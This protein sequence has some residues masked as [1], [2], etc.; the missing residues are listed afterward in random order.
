[1][2]N[3]KFQELV[4]DAYKKAKEGGNL[5][6]ILYSA[7]STHGFSEITDIEGYVKA[8]AT[9]MLYLKSKVTGESTDIY[10]YDLV[11]YKVRN[12]EKTIY[13]RLRNREILL[14]F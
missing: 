1:M 13:V 2:K 5:V 11:D 4:I 14:T 12:N 7:V 8:S 9:D 10:E 3:E 6:G